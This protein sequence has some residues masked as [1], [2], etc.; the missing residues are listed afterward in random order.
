VFE[1]DDVDRTRRQLESDPTSTWTLYYVLTRALAPSG[2]HFLL[3]VAGYVGPPTADGSV[4]IGYAIATEHQRHGYAT[5]AVGALVDR[6]FADSAVI[7]VV[8]T[9]YAWLHPS[10]GVLRRTGFVEV[11]RNAKADL[12]RFEHRR[13]PGA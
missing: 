8:A 9:T 12:I 13:E 1:R 6:A 5:E 7:V 3:G 10:I 2:L 11:C 4:E